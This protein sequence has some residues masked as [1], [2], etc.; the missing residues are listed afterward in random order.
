M[1]HWDYNL[2]LCSYCQG[3]SLSIADELEPIFRLFNDNHKILY[4]F[5][6]NIL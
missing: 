6:A 5:I 3:V 4:E 1:Y 2:V